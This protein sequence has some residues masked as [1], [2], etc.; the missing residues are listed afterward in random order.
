MIVMR[1]PLWTLQLANLLHVGPCWLNYSI[2]EMFRARLGQSITFWHTWYGVDRNIDEQGTHIH[3]SI[4]M[5]NKWQGIGKQKFSQVFSPRYGTPRW[6]L[7][8][9]SGF[10]DQCQYLRSFSFC[11]MLLLG[12]KSLEKV[13]FGLPNLLTPSKTRVSGVWSTL[14]EGLS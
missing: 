2:V 10:N 9:I 12:M 8:S 13:S 1:S 6:S 14:G 7:R 5:E 4:E 3:Q 11:G